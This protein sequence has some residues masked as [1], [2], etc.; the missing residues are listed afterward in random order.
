LRYQQRGLDE[1]GFAVMNNGYNEVNRALEL[2]L[3]E[4][5]FV[6]PT[7]MESGDPNQGSFGFNWI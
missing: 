2:M 6:K 1:D 7:H 5:G 4:C 3:S